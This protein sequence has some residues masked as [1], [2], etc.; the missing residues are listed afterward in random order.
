MIKEKELF[1]ASYITIKLS[2]QMKERKKKNKRRCEGEKKKMISS[3]YLFFLWWSSIILCFLCT[4]YFFPCLSHK[5]FFTFPFFII[6]YAFSC[7]TNFYVNGYES[8]YSI[9][10]KNGQ[11]EETRRKVNINESLFFPAFL[12][13]PTLSYSLSLSIYVLRRGAQAEW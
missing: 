10:D 3:F 1:F 2:Y 7:T 6:S 8:N 5:R 12:V 11:K 4:S 9:I 13:S